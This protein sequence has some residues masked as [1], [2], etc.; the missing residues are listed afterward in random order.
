MHDCPFNYTVIKLKST[1]TPNVMAASF[2]VYANILRSITDVVLHKAWYTAIYMYVCVFLCVYQSH[3]IQMYSEASDRGS[4][5]RQ[6]EMCVRQMEKWKI[7]KQTSGNERKHDVKH[8]SC[9]VTPANSSLV[10]FILVNYILFS[11]LVRG[12]MC[13]CESFKSVYAKHFDGCAA[14]EWVSGIKIY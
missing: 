11:S 6:R 8:F 9:N 2:S 12:Y 14:K 4:Q 10:F 1:W 13:V 7:N 3:T 5:E